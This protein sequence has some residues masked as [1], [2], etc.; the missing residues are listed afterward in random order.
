[1]KKIN[2][3][4]I[5][6]VIIIV[7]I[8]IVSL[9]FRKELFIYFPTSISSGKNK[10]GWNPNK[11]F[12][13]DYN[14]KFTNVNSYPVKT[15]KIWKEPP[16]INPGSSP[17]SFPSL[18]PQDLTHQIWND[19]CPKCELTK[20]EC[21]YYPCA[22][23]NLKM[24]NTYNGI[25]AKGD[26]WMELACKEAKFGVKHYGGPF[27]AVILRINSKDNKIIE[28]WKSHNHVVIWNDPTAHA[29]VSTI[30]IACKDLSKRFSKK[31]GK[32]ISIF[33][34]GNIVDPIT[35]ERIILCNI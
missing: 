22:T 10:S 2:V 21:K 15:T 16:L 27:G 30:R 33:D 34:L 26:E 12:C 14:S 7:V 9:C 28:Y 3:G 23:S 20:D 17:S 29:E 6:S 8:I 32:N 25:E 11:K 18:N 1:M 5:I 13:D 19:Y 24:G 31:T 35:N 4:I